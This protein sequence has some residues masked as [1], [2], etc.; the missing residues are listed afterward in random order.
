MKNQLAKEGWGRGCFSACLLSKSPGARI[1]AS[2]MDFQE[3][4][5]GHSAFP[6]LKVRSILVIMTFSPVLCELIHLLTLPKRPLLNHGNRET[7][8]EGMWHIAH[9]TLLLMVSW[10]FLTQTDH[11]CVCWAKWKNLLWW[12]SF[13]IFCTPSLWLPFLLIICSVNRCSTWI[14]RRCALGPGCQLG[15]SSCC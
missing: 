7:K 12:S 5:L 11:T 2:P 6:C 14:E 3:A 8:A 13:P 9:W 4:A 10:F 1:P 15:T